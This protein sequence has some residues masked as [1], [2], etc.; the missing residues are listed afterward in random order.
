MDLWPE[1]REA[2]DKTPPE[3]LTGED[4]DR[5]GEM[6]TERTEVFERQIVKEPAQTMIGVFAQLSVFRDWIDNGLPNSGDATIRGFYDRVDATLRDAA[7]ARGV[8]VPAYVGPEGA[9]IS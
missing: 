4:S 2:Q 7:A 8:E 9:P 5:Y 6:L 3:S 1:W